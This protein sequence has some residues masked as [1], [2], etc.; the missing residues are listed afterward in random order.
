[1]SNDCISCGMPME[2]IE[3]QVA[4]EISKGFCVHCTSPDGSMKAYD[5][6][7]HNI[8]QYL[9][10]AHGMNETEAEATARDMMTK[11]PAWVEA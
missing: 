5:E 6:V 8:T 9:I 7:L 2:T 3:D 11:L 10:S 1:M 4:S